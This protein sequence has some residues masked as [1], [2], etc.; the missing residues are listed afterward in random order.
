MRGDVITTSTTAAHYHALCAV[1]YLWRMQQKNE[2]IGTIERLTPMILPRGILTHAPEPGVTI[3]LGATMPTEKVQMAMMP[4]IRALES[5]LLSIVCRLRTNK[6]TL[7]PV[8][9]CRRWRFDSIFR[10]V[11]LLLEGTL[12]APSY[13]PGRAS[14]AVSEPFSPMPACS[15]YG[16]TELFEPGQAVAVEFICCWSATTPTALVTFDI[17]YERLQPIDDW[18]VNVAVDSEHASLFFTLL[19]TEPSNRRCFRLT[20]LYAVVSPE[21]LLAMMPKSK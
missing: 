12:S 6:N 17:P 19:F 15:F 21:L 8:P 1:K 3:R 20:N 7:L 16:V 11:D 14:R 9:M 18:G 10:Q 13:P 5:Q 2:T 4:A